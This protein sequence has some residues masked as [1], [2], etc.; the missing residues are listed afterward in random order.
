[1]RVGLSGEGQAQTEE[2]VQSRPRIFMLQ[3][4]DIARKFRLVYPERGPRPRAVHI[5]VEAE[6]VLKVVCACAT[7]SAAGTLR[8]VRGAGLAVA[9][10]LW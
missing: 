2:E 9:P 1:M 7:F 3:T 10:R 6:V 4:T 8:T 5:H